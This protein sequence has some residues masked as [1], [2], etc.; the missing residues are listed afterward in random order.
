MSLAMLPKLWRATW[1]TRVLHAVY[2]LVIVV[3][4]VGHY[5]AVARHQRDPAAAEEGNEVMETYWRDA[6]PP[7]A[8]AD[9]PLWLLKIHAGMLLA[10]PVGAD[11]PGS[12]V[13]FLLFVLGGRYLWTRGRRSLLLCCVLPFVLTLVAAALHKYPYGGSARV[14]QHLAPMACLLIAAGGAGLLEGLRAPWQVRGTLVLTLLLTAVGLAGTVRDIRRPFKAEHEYFVRALMHDF[15]LQVGPD[16][17][18]VFGNPYGEL[19]MAAEWYLRHGRPGVVWVGSPAVP[20][21]ER[22]TVWLWYFTFTEPTESTMAAL[23][24]DRAYGHCVV[25]SRTWTLPPDSPGNPNSY[26]TRACLM[27]Q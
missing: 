21:S 11:A 17:V 8:P 2:S 6:F 7:D 16:D 5:L 3:T 24:G 1:G 12:A 27:P 18:V 10:Y 13:P 22:R 14:A 26:A 23:L 25:S 15:W 4:F 9:V 19:P 20:N